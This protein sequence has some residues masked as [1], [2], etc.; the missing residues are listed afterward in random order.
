LKSSGCIYLTNRFYQCDVS[1]EAQVKSLVAFASKEFG[2]CKLTKGQLHIMFNNAGIMHPQDDTAET[3]TSPV[4]DMTM[5]V[6]VKGVWY[7]C[8][9][10]IPAIRKSG[11]GSVINTASF[12]A[13][14]GSATAQIACTERI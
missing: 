13:L 4:W 11:G 2:T 5:N 14:M 8:K 7:G 12:V 3:T 1:D 6:N 9:H 10:A